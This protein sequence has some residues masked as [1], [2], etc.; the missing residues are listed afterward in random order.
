MRAIAL[1]A[2]AAALALAPAPARAS[3]LPG[4]DF[5][6]RPT[7]GVGLGAGLGWRPGGSFAVTWPAMEQLA[8]GAA[9]ASTFTGGATYDLRGVYRFV[10]GSREGPAIAGI[11]GLWGAVGGLGP[12]PRFSAAAPL[13]PSIGFGLAYSPLDKLSIRLNLAY[14]PFFNY[15]TEVLGF[16]GGPP[17]SGIE[18]AYALSPGFEVTAGLNGNGDLLGLSYAF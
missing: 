7:L 18:A 12:D 16:I 17:S 5:G 2:L 3:S 4:A 13:A 11:L 15:G 9:V 1:A 14:S 6:D 8:V 10:D